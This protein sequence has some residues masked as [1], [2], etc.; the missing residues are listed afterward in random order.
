MIIR[1][2]KDAYGNII[3][4]DKSRNIPATEIVTEDS[5]SKD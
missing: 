3:W 4:I 2:K 1:T 5:E